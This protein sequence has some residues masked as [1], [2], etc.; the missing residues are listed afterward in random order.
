MLT[1][2]SWPCALSIRHTV[3]PGLLQV[4]LERRQNVPRLFQSPLFSIDCFE[5]GAT[6][7]DHVAA[8]PTGANFI[9]LRRRRGGG[10]S[11]SA[12]RAA[13]AA[14]SGAEVIFKG[15]DHSGSRRRAGEALAIGGGKYWPLFRSAVDALKR[16]TLKWSARTDPDAG[17]CRPN[18]SQPSRRL[19]FRAPHRRRIHEISHTRASC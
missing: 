9:G 16:R 6:L 11:V 1:V 18:T 10:R 17:L 3:T 2:L 12:G 8:K 14:D 13:P 5:A 4:S 15:E 7:F 19:I